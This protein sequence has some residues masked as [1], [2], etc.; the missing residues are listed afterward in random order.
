MK[1]PIIAEDLGGV[2]PFVRNGE[3]MFVHHPQSEQANLDK[4][5]PKGNP[6]WKANG[7]APGI[8]V[9]PRSWVHGTIPAV[10]LSGVT[11]LVRN[12]EVAGVNGSQTPVP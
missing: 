5:R 3:M 9:R 4:A 2:A 6:V 11:I 8:V 12:R 7:S 10:D 1:R